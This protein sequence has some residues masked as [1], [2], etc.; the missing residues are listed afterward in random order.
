MERSDHLD[1]VVEAEDTVTIETPAGD[2]YRG[3]SA[4]LT[5]QNGESASRSLLFLFEKHGSFFKYRLT[6]RPAMRVRLDRRLDRFM[7]LT[8]DRVTPKAAAGDPTAPAAFRHGGRADPV[9]GHTIRWTWTEGPVAGV[10]HEHV[11]G[12]DG[13]VTWRVLSGP[14]QGHSGREDDYAVYPV[15]DSVY[16]VSYLAASGYTLTV[17]LNFVTREMFG[18]ASGADAWHPGHGTFDVVR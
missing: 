6:H 5:L 11:F 1:A 12:T 10:T 18:F 16:A 15:S 17:V 4:E 7:A 3:W 14:Q 13:T 8:L 2:R 9:R